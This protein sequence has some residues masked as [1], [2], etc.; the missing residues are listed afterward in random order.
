MSLPLYNSS[1]QIKAPSMGRGGVLKPLRAVPASVCA[2]HSLVSC[3]HLFFHVTPQAFSHFTFERSGHQL[4]VVDVQ[5]VG[6]LYT[7][8]QIHTERGTD[9][10]DGNLGRQGKPACPWRPH[11][12]QN[13]RAV[14]SP[15]KAGR[16]DIWGA[17]RLWRRDPGA[18]G[19]CQFSM[20][21]TCPCHI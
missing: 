2:A 19:S 12:P 13:L 20:F 6:D 9:F 18:S 5:G 15:K 10:G 1:L 14:C 16:G 17:P 21:Y 11:S 4:I 3:G 8:P 7:D